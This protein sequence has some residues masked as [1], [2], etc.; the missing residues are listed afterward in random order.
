MAIYR[1]MFFNA[2]KSYAR[3]TTPTPISFIQIDGKNIYIYLQPLQTRK[4]VIL[5]KD[6]RLKG[7]RTSRKLCLQSWWT[8][9]NGIK[10]HNIRYI[11]V[12][13]VSWSCWISIW[14]LMAHAVATAKSLGD[15]IHFTVRVCVVCCVCVCVHRNN[16]PYCKYN[17]GVHLSI[18]MFATQWLQPCTT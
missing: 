3:Y 14:V 11:Y 17:D 15:E 18:S 8:G 13:A 2:T 9:R 10:I 7:A 5:S 4:T 6:R 1:K 16:H 12:G